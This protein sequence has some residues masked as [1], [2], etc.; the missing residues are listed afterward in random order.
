MISL[1][2]CLAGHGGY[3]F[4]YQFRR[5]PS[6]QVGKIIKHFD[7]QIFHVN[8]VQIIRY[9]RDHIFSAT[10]IFDLVPEFFDFRQIRL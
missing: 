5:L 7:K 6:G 2:R 3:F 4:Q 10:E 8:M 9:C 1:Y